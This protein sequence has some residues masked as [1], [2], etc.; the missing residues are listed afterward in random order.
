MLG[1]LNFGGN[2]NDTNFNGV[3]STTRSYGFAIPWYC[4]IDIVSVPYLEGGFMI[5]YKQ[6]RDLII[7]QCDRKSC[8][9][10]LHFY[11]SNL[12]EELEDAI[13]ACG[14]G[15][16]VTMGVK[17]HGRSH[18]CRKCLQEGVKR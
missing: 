4:G 13:K 1:F 17:K 14:W 8:P 16:S 15:V 2:Q 6:N 11:A 7:V 10:K 18:T 5:D 3:V 9:S 12:K